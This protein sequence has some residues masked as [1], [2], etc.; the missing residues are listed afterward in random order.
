ME[1]GETMIECT[2][3]D[4]VSVFLLGCLATCACAVIVRFWWGDL[5]DEDHDSFI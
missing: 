3:A 2:L 4:I 5:P 1:A